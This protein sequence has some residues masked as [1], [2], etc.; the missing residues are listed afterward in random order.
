MMMESGQISAG[1]TLCRW[2]PGAHARAL[3]GLIILFALVGFA[4]EAVCGTPPVTQLVDRPFE[5]VG[6][7]PP[8]VMLTMSRDHQYFFR[9]YDDYT[10]LNPEDGKSQIEYTYE[11]Y[12][13]YYGYFH[14]RRCYAYQN[15][16]F[17]QA[18]R[19][20]MKASPCATSRSQPVR[21]LLSGRQC[22]NVPRT[23]H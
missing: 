16:R 12:I 10:D 9:A 22:L 19:G 17:E 21:T 15:S 13:E 5:E 7:V 11:D 3:R 6:A 23:R 20:P 8:V 18:S 1:F 2:H 4:L 14:P